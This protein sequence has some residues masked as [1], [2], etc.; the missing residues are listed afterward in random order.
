MIPSGKLTWLLNMT[1]YRVIVDLPIQNGGSFQFV[2][3]QRLPHRK[4][5]HTSNAVPCH[6]KFVSPTWRWSGF[7]KW[8]TK[9]EI[10][11][12]LMTSVGPMDLQ[13]LVVSS[14]RS[15]CGIYDHSKIPNGEASHSKPKAIPKRSTTLLWG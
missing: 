15:R 14:H 9:S 7:W 6:P 1:S 5:C 12:P 13:S 11:K 2:F 8:H 4:W 10:P 3:C